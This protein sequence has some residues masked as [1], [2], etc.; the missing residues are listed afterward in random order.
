MKRMLWVILIMAVGTTFSSPLFPLYQEQFNMSDLEIT[1]L[2]AVYAAFL[3]PTLLIAGPIGN[4]RGLKN[5]LLTSIAISIL[6]AIVFIVSN[7]PW[8]L[9]LARIFEGIAFGAFMGNATAFLLKQSPKEKVIKALTLSSM[10]I[11]IGFGLGPAISGLLIQYAHFQPIRLP[12][13]LLTILLLS[14]VIAL[15]SISD[16]Q[17]QNKNTISM[18]LKISVPMNMRSV[19]WSFIALSGFIVFSLNGIVLSLIPSFTKNILHTSNLSIS[20][21]LILLLL[22]GGGLAQRT[23]WPYSPVTRVRIGILFL[24]MG[25]WFMIISGETIN[26]GLLWT[27]IFIQAI[28]GGWA[29]Q[30]SL[31]LAGSTPEPID[32]AGVIST[33]YSASYSGFIIPIIGVGVVSSFFGLFNSLIILNVIATIIVMFLVGCSFKYKAYFVDQALIK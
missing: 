18:K 14:A 13:I 17:S 27:G 19:F 21:L 4:V 9:Y 26:L 5:V 3:L 25:S 15:W 20:G 32:R 29:F 24:L 30:A 2:F 22:G 11:M 10:A 23:S 33:Y 31:Q 1:L 7:Q 12:Y 16:I 28:G 8:L 6:S